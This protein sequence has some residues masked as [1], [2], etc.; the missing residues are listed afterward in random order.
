MDLSSDCFYK[1]VFGW[2]IFKKKK[3]KIENAHHQCDVKN[4]EEKQ[5]ILT[6]KKQKQTHVGHFCLRN[7]WKD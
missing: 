2:Q 7:D 5:Q 4:D 6:F 3:K 1:E